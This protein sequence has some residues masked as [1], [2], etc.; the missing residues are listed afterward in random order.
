M[1]EPITCHRPPCR[2]SLM[3]K[4]AWLSPGLILCGVMAGHLIEAAAR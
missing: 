3:T 1:P 2:E 4:L